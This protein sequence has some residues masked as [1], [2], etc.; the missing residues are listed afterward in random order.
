MRSKLQNACIYKTALG[1]RLLRF[2]TSKA[3]AYPTMQNGVFFFYEGSRLN[4]KTTP[5]NYGFLKRIISADDVAD[6]FRWHTKQ[7]EGVTGIYSVISWSANLYCG[8]CMCNQTQ[9]E[10]GTFQR[11]E[12]YKHQS[13]QQWPQKGSVLSDSSKQPQRENSQICPSPSLLPPPPHYKRDS[14]RPPHFK[15]CSAVL[16]F[17]NNIRAGKAKRKES[18]IQ[19]PYKTSA[20]HFFHWLTSVESANQNYFR[21]MLLLVCKFF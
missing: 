4:L 21:C 14:H 10:K 13:A 20:A 2:Q 6:A 9:Q 5:R 17:V 8:S 12:I 7:N 1:L 3:V 16:D 11:R 19:T 15:K 18:L